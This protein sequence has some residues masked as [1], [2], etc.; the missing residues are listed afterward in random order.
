MKNMVSQQ[1]F[2]L[3]KEFVSGG[4]IEIMEGYSKKSDHKDLYE[5]IFTTEPYWKSK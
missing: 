1:I 3:Y 2:R 5:E 4:R